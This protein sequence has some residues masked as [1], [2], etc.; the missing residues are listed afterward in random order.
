MIRSTA[1]IGAGPA[2][3]AA[4]YA[5]RL[6]G[7]RVVLFERDPQI[8]GRTTTWRQGELKIDSGAGFFTN[9][10]PTLE[11]L[12]PKLGIRDQVNVLSRHSVLVQDGKRGELTLGSAGSFVRFPFLGA[13]DKVRMA[14]ATAWLTVRY[15]GLDI[16]SP[17]SLSALDDRSIADDARER[18]GENAYQVVVRS[19]IEP[20]WYFSCEEVSRALAV[21]LQARAATARFYAFRDGMDSICRALAVN[22]ETHTSAAVEPLVC[23]TDGRLLVRYAREGAPYEERFDEVIVATTASTAHT[24]TAQL[25]DGVVPAPMRD[26]LI[27]QGYVPNVHATFMVDRGACPAGTSSMFPCGPAQKRVAA[28]SFNSFKRQCA[29]ALPADKELVCVFLTADESRALLDASEAQIYEHC[30]RLARAFCPEL[31]AEATP[32]R[33]IARSEAIPVHSVGR[34]R[35]AAALDELAPGPVV[36]AGDYLTA[37]TVD[38]AL[39]SGLRAA[40][41]LG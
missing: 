16:T 14:S 12:M 20:F 32:F 37:A 39:R 22:I 38:G 25:G 36:F 9:F 17:Q 23:E 40:D 26:F 33:W 2:G 13:R 1:V 4:A 34:F 18:V 30:W 15:G 3:C 35:M 27:T 28:L 5:L 6:K 7:R 8:G 11:S 10:Y 29:D 31:P 19:G 41:K 21:A 24:L